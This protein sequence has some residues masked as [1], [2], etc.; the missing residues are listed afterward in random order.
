MFD[1]CQNAFEANKDKL[2]FVLVMLDKDIEDEGIE[3]FVFLDQIKAYAKEY[4]FE[5]LLMRNDEGSNIFVFY[6]DKE[7]KDF[8][9]LIAQHASE[10]K[11]KGKLTV[12]S[13]D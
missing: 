4:M 2:T 12:I 1:G 13:E 8:A 5:T 10:Q 6:K 11:K 7:D 9:Y 3:V